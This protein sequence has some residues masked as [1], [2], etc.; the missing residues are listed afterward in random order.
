MSPTLEGRWPLAWLITVAG[1]LGMTAI[2]GTAA[3]LTGRPLGWMALLVAADAVLLLRLTGIPA[4]A[5]RAALAL[6]AV[7]IC[8]LVSNWLL[9]AGMVGA[10]MGLSPLQAAPRLSVDLAWLL[11]IQANGS[12]DLLAIAAALVLA[13]WWTR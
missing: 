12:L 5:G 11:A 8:T 1:V 2:W 7:A 10:Q 6:A 9:A 3:V 4:G 13:W